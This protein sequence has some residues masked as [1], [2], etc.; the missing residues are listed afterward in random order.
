MFLLKNVSLGK[1]KI[2]FPIILWFLLAA[3]A[4]LLEEAR[5][6]ENFN[7]YFIYKYVFIHA[8]ALQNL[9][10]GEPASV[11]GNL[12]GPLFSLL[13]APF[14]LLNDY[15]GCFLWCLA[16][17]W[18]L[19]IGIKQLKIDYN[20]RM[21]IL[22]ISV[23]EMMTSIHSVEFNSMVAGWIILSYVMIEKGNDF[24]GTFFIAIGMM[25][26]IYG[27]VGLVFFLFSKD[28]FR[29]ILYFVFWVG[30]LFCLPMLISSKSFIIQS[31]K[32]WYMKLLAKNE[33]NVIAFNTHNMKDI[34]VMGLFRRIG[35][36]HQLSNIA[37][38]IPAAICYLIPLFRIN[39]YKLATFRLSYLAFA[40]IG[41]VIYSSSAESATYVIAMAGVG[42]WY[43]V[44][45]RKSLSNK[46]ILFF[47]LILT[48]LSPTNLFPVYLKEHFVVPFALKALPCFIIWLIIA[49]QL[50][51]KNFENTLQT[52]SIE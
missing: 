42:I 34:S 13:I 25:T 15:V 7:N 52:E 44:Q 28:K 32:D 10:V 33:K 2:P 23:I 12:Y 6:P 4:V 30:V 48:S 24:W 45:P 11:Y 36:M 46:L 38:I 19:Y 43:V 17:A 3:V 27:V 9:Y 35:K 20:Y 50:I 39:Q 14:A 51:G 21:L 47:T 41:V 16:N 31:Y 26:K 22:L 18:V 37:V 1:L 40:L 8:R 29:F 5:G 49:F